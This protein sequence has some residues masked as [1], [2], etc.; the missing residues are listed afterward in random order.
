M[1]PCREK[2]RKMRI[3]FDG[4]MA[5]SKDHFNHKRKAME[6]AKPLKQQNE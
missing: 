6:S 1:P 5:K 4:P 2:Y 3:K